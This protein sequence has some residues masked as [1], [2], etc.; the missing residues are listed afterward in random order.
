[1]ASKKQIKESVFQEFLD[2]VKERAH[3]IYLERT[4]NGISGDTMNDW[5]KAEKEMKKKY[6]IK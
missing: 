6:N 1:M 5:L 4:E 2:E 3:E